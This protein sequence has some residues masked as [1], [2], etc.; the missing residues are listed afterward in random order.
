MM[1]QDVLGTFFF[2]VT[3]AKVVTFCDLKQRQGIQFTKHKCM[4][5]LPKVQHTSRNLDTLSLTAQLF[6]LTP[7]VLAVDTR[8]DALR[9]LTV[10]GE[11][12]LLMLSL[13]YYSLY[14][15]RSVETQHRIF[16]NGVT[17]SAEVALN[18]VEYN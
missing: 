8:T 14:M 17:M 11:E 13:T 5:G 10:L 18:L 7:L 15:L 6:L 2:A 4:P 1:Y 12:V 16:H 9:E 3:D